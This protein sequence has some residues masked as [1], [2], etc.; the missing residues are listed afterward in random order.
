LK[1]R[2]NAT[3]LFSPRVVLPAF[4][5]VFTL[6]SVVSFR[7]KS[8]TWDEPI[9]LT[10]GYLALAKS[11]YRVEPTHPPF[12]RMW[13][14]LPLLAMN[15]VKADPSAIE[16][17]PPAEWMPQGYGFAHRFLYLEHDAD[18]LLYAARFMAL[19][20]GL[21]LGILIFSWV[22]E[23]LGAGP[24]VLALMF[25][26]LEPNI[27]AH[28]ALVTTD[29]GVTCFIFGAV[30]FLW[31]LCRR[32]SVLNVGGVTLFTVLAVVSKFSAVL[33]GPIMLALL[34]TAA[35]LRAGI[36]FK[37]AA[38]L[39]LLLGAASVAG[40]WAVYGLQYAPSASEVWR[41]NEGDFPVAQERVPTLSAIA[42]W[43]DRHK[44]LPNAFTQGFF[45][46]QATSRLSA[47]FAGEVSA[48]GWWYYFPAA[49]LVK[50][51]SVLIAL[52]LVG[53][54]LL[55]PAWRR[56]SALDAAFIVIPIAVYMG[57]AMESRINIGIRHIL[58]VFPFV[59]LA[60]TAAAKQLLSWRPPLGRS[61]LAAS[62]ALWLVGFAT[63]YPHTLTFFNVLA[64]GPAGG[65][66]YLSD[67]N[68]DWGQ[69][70]KPLKTWMGQK[71]L[72]HINLAYFGTA[73]PAYYGISCTH[74]PGAPFFAE[75]SIAKPV[76][77]GYVAISTTILSGVYLTPD[78]RLFYR[79]FLAKQP[80]A[81]VGNSI[82]VYWVESWPEAENSESSE[83]AAE[84]HAV[85]AD[86]LLF[87]LRWP[88]LAAVHFQK[89][90]DR[91]P[92]DPVLLARLGLALF[93]AGETVRAID[94]LHAAVRASPTDGEVRSL[95]ASALLRNR[96]VAEAEEHA[97][98]AVTLRADDPVAHDVLG[99]VL[100]VTGRTDP[101]LSSFKKAL[102]LAPDF[103]DARF[104][105]KRLEEY[106]QQP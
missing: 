95:L 9:H 101:A 51:P 62:G 81:T 89:S 88:D 52:F 20:W 30:Y 31:R 41:L 93:E 1:S 46:S 43:I 98:E 47:Y 54:V 11:D 68:L 38:A 7:Q 84:I 103:E 65:L 73:D 77:P 12:L 17:V 6:L 32:P 53:V 4:A 80:V 37:R 75:A 64:G 8:A 60:A 85:L 33:L 24:A 21:L 55:I 40:I 10:A 25:Y 49:F 96:Q 16:A 18:R 67:S 94:R 102:E 56:Y 76:L 3:A 22:R 28:S 42:G 69:D 58:P 23:W 66:A 36:G 86:R 34:A 70:L 104:H 74:L 19:A 29:F 26:T 78:W 35:V 106:L 91:R 99:V 44:L 50:T 5:V 39:V 92:A 48:E 15:N 90:L 27:A 14:A 59:L 82:R 100:A 97:R 63:V 61:V 79:G 2:V 71:K 13:A 45:L 57:F 87:G 105:M 83:K 72:A